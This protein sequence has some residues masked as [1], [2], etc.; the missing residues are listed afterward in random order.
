VRES[1]VKRLPFQYGYALEKLPSID[2]DKR[3]DE[4]LCYGMDVP[5]L[6]EQIQE[7]IN[8]KRNIKND[9]QEKILNPDVYVGDQ[10]DV[11][12]G[13]LTFGA[14]KRIRVKGD[15]SQIHER[16]V[17]SEYA[18]NADLGMLAGDEQ[19]AIGVNS[20]QAGQTSSS[21]R[22]SA[23]A[24]ATVNSNSSMRIEEMI[25]LIKETLFD[26]WAKTWVEIVFKN[27][28]DNV[29]NAITGD[30]Y[31]FGRKGHR[32]SVE[33]DVRINFGMTLD[34]EK[35]IQDLLGIYQMTAQNPNINPRIVERMLKKILDLRIGEDTDLDEL[36]KEVEQ[37][38]QNQPTPEEVAMEQEKQKLLGGGI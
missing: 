21:D 33:Y 29:I 2:E 22:R 10:A 7:E 27:A 35:R 24:L 28:D 11:K 8:R 26:H 14:G 9:I 18:L 6:L 38:A 32:N 30:E 19:G 37:D 15:I 12:V 3:S 17:P 13:D 31:P 23:I 5:T 16:Q 34:K 4:I 25:M 20:I 1:K 36:Y